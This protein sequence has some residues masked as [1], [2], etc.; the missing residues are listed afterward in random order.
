MGDALGFKFL[1]PLEYDFELLNVVIKHRFLEGPA[2]SEVQAGNYEIFSANKSLFFISKNMRLLPG[3]SIIMAILLDKPASE[4]YTN[5]TCPTPRCGSNLTKATPR[6]GRIYYV[7]PRY[8]LD[9]N[10][11]LNF[12]WLTIIL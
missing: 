5:E 10:N 3:A 6:G 2:S 1:V 4:V 8:G 7:R 12:L 9:A 11:V